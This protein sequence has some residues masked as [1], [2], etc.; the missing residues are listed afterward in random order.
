MVKIETNS[1]TE[2]ISAS[3]T[4]ESPELAKTLAEHL[5]DVAQHQVASI[6]DGS[7]MRVIDEPYLPTKKYAPSNTKNAAIGAFVGL[8][9]STM[10]VALQVVLDDRVRSEESL[11]ERYGIAVLG[12]IPDYDAARKVSN[13]YGYGK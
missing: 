8:V 12:S 2:I 6:V 9:L 10:A 5:A 13:N 1:L 7:S 11:E 4:A 3:V